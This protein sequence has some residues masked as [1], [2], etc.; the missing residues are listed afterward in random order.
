MVTIT[1]ECRVYGTATITSDWDIQAIVKDEVA[2]QI[3]SLIFDD[4]VINVSFVSW[5]KFRTLVIL[6]IPLFL[7]SGS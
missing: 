7:F 5:T 2:Q 1:S 4:G 6:I 3:P